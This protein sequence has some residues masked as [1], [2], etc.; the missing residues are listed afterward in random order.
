MALQ[1]EGQISFSNIAGELGFSTPFSLRAM[2]SE[3]GF[4]TPDT[5]SEFYGYDAGGGGGVTLIQFWTTGVSDVDPY[6]RCFLTN[7]IAAWHNGASSTPEIGDTVYADSDGNEPL[8]PGFYGVDDT[9]FDP[10]K[11]TI[12]VAKGGTVIGLYMC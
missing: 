1:G 6:D 3:A 4:S 10:T 8:K 2:S 9:K 12:E 5:M 11:S 7:N